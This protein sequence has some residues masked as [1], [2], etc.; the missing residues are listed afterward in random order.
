[1]SNITRSY[2]QIDLFALTS[3]TT[4]DTGVWKGLYTQTVPA[5]DTNIQNGKILSNT[6]LF[7]VDKT[8]TEN[9]QIFF[10]ININGQFVQNIDDISNSTGAQ[11]LG[12]TVFKV[13]Y[14]VQFINST[15]ANVYLNVVQVK[16]ASGTPQDESSTTIITPLTFD[17][18]I[19]NNIIVEMQM[20]SA[21]S[22]MDVS[23]FLID[24]KIN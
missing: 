12:L 22:N 10:R 1:M 9:T 20:V 23:Q 8:T 15:I 11:P 4:G 16:N 6:I 18:S 24:S 7:R 21:A 13:D 3:F 2:Q 14:T 17:R 5:N 19:S